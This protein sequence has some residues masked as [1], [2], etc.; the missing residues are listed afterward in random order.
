MLIRESAAGVKLSETW[1]QLIQKWWN[2]ER[3]G[4]ELGTLK[5]HVNADPLA[6]LKKSSAVVADAFDGA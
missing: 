4:E 3:T 5:D 1:Y 2:L 6:L